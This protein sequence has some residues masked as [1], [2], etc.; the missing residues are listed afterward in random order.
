MREKANATEIA[1]A[2]RMTRNFK[3]AEEEST[4]LIVKLNADLEMKQF[5]LDTQAK[6]FQVRLNTTT[7]D[8]V[9]KYNKLEREFEVFK[10]LVNYEI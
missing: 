9:A 4:K 8:F 5:E 3:K 2:R 6:N 10:R 7:R 1:M